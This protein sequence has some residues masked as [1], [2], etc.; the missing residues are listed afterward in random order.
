M[1]HSGDACEIRVTGRGADS[2]PPPIINICDG[3]LFLDFVHVKLLKLS[4][5][6]SVENYFTD[7]VLLSNIVIKITRKYLKL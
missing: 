4:F 5:Y 6:P 1:H 2:A 7:E 3:L